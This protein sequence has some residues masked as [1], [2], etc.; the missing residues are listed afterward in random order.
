MRRAQ[1]ST[2]HLSD[3][4]TCC[5]PAGAATLL[6]CF[7]ASSCCSAGRVCDVLRVCSLGA[8]GVRP[9]VAVRQAAAEASMWVA[10]D[11]FMPN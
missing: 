4:Q 10:S 1:L 11:C 2:L 3:P 6:L 5:E 7:S 8:D 9:S